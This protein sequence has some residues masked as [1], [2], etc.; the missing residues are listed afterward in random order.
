MP[1]IPKLQ[2]DESW[3]GEARHFHQITG[4]TGSGTMAR[5]TSPGRSR[6]IRGRHVLPILQPVALEIRIMQVLLQRSDQGYRGL[7][8]HAVFLAF[9]D[10]RQAFSRVWSAHVF[11]VWDG[12]V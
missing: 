10:L 2:Q 6:Y 3:R 8:D 7:P 1:E 11:K 5:L 9:I 12:D 4:T